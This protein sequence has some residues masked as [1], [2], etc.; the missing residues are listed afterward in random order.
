MAQT[1][2]ANHPESLR[3]LGL[4]ASPPRPQLIVDPALQMLSEPAS[5]GAE[6]TPASPWSAATT[7]AAPRT[8]ATPAPALPVHAQQPPAPAPQPATPTTAQSCANCGTESTPLWRRDTEGRS[9]CNACGLYAKSRRQPRPVTLGRTSTPS[10][11]FISQQPPAVS[12]TGVNEPPVA[13]ANPSHTGGTCPGDGRCDGTGGASA[14]A[15][16]PAFNNNMAANSQEQPQAQI[17]PTGVPDRPSGAPGA[18]SCTNCGTSTTP[19]W[20]RDDAGNNICNACGLYHK[21]HG[22]HRPEAMKKS[23]IKRRKRVTAAGPS[24]QAEQAAAEA[25]VAVGR[26]PDGTP[27]TPENDHSEGLDAQHKKKRQRR[28]KPAVPGPDPNTPIG[29]PPPGPP[30]TSSQGET[31]VESPVPLA[32]YIDEAAL[33]E[34]STSPVAQ[35]HRDNILPPP[36]LPGMEDERRYSNR[37]RF[38]SPHGGLELPPINLGNNTERGHAPGYLGAPPRERDEGASAAHAVSPSPLHHQ[39]SHDPAHP[40]PVPTRAELEKHYAD[41]RAE[42]AR[43]EDML[44]RTDVMLA[45]VKRGIDEA[46]IVENGV[47]ERERTRE[48]SSRTGR[49]SVGVE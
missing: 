22:T 32:R 33:V 45:G 35:Y 40:P 27:G 9:I 39:N 31:G 24:K 41:L 28:T 5:L 29:L 20:R 4:P 14:C 10:Y 44:R 26:G 19:L 3:V 23:V 8:P 46:G 2:A 37:G 16:C 30:S 11:T 36:T 1:A 6:K 34:P 13:T 15:G 7:V 47:E 17:R 38:S 21:L 48:R 42:R 43:L 12:S 18:L 25:L 49:N